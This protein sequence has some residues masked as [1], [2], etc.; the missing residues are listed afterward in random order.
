[1]DETNDNNG[2]MPIYFKNH[3]IQR[4]YNYLVKF[5]HYKPGF[6][7]NEFQVK[8]VS[9][10]HFNF[11]KEISKIGGVFPQIFPTLDSDG[12]EL[13]LEIEEDNSGKVSSLILDMQNRV[14]DRNGYYQF[15]DNSKIGD[16]LIQVVDNTGDNVVDYIAKNC[17]FLKSEDIKYTYAEQYAIT[18]MLSFGFDFYE[19]KYHKNQKK[20]SNN[21]EAII[22]PDRLKI[23]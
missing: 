18:Y 9:L 5:L 6:L 2:L 8:S 12:L 16:I 21:I 4:S 14:I 10:P 3:E 13:R 17:F 19:Y 7:I 23:L 20:I 1:M 22:S 15:P 11:K